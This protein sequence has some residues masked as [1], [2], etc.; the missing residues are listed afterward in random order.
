MVMKLQIESSRKAGPYNHVT[1]RVSTVSGVC[2]CACVYVCVC[3]CVCGVCACVRA[4][5]CVCVRACVC[6]CACAC[7]YMCLSVCREYLVGAPQGSL[8]YPQEGR[9]RRA[10]AARM[11]ALKQPLLSTDTV[12]CRMLEETT[13][14]CEPCLAVKYLQHVEQF[15]PA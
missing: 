1:A 4:C 3:V 9:R 8:L 12:S 11:S 5:V 14:T 13:S 7:T 2:V 15:V 6:V 10:A